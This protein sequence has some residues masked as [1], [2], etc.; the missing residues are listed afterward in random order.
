[1]QEIKENTAASKAADPFHAPGYERSRWAYIAECAFEYFIALLVADPFLTKLLTYMGLD[2]A[3]IGIIQSLISVAFLFQLC[4]IFVVQ[5]IT[6]VKKVAATVH[7]ISQ[8][9]FMCLYLIPFL[10][11]A[12][13]YKTVVIIVC[14]LAAYFGN[15]LVT[16][17]IFRWGNSYVDPERRARYAATKEMISLLSGVI[18]TFVMSKVIDSYEAAGDL[19]TGFI[20]TAIVMAVVCGIDFLCLMLMKNRISEP[21]KKGETVPFRE[22]LKILLTNKGFICVLVL[23]A[24]WQFANYMTLGFMGTYKQGELGLTV[25]AVQIINIAGQ[26][27]RF[28]LSRPF[29][30]YTDKRSYSKGVALGMTVAAV[31]YLINIFTTPTLWWLVVV[32]TVVYNVA[33]AGISANLFNIVYNFVD[34]KYFVQASA[35]K[36]SIGG[37]I[38]FGASLI[39]SKI[40]SS[41]QANGNTVFGIPLY[42]QQVLSLISFVFAVAAII[43]AHVVLQKQKIVAR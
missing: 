35:I 10:P 18:V 5:R 32:Y 27:A 4:S 33:L 39:G 24:L 13:E 7:G 29:G 12:A 2:D 36:N 11:F 17:V 20:F 42:G 38:G 3:T 14:F 37:V 21:P 26:M 23:T 22:V 41:V 40:L 34:E 25:Y 43:F 1:M 31:G 8:L 19:R 30:R 9:L 28:A 15:Y 16:S 6:N